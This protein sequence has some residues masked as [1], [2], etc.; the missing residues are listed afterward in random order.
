MLRITGDAHLELGTR[1]AR[2]AAL[3]TGALP[4]SFYVYQGEELGLPEVEDL[5]PEARRDPVWLR[6]GFTDPGRDG[7]R[8]PV[9]WSGDS[10]PFGFSGD[11]PFTRRQR[12]RAVAAAAPVVRGLHRRVRARR[13]RLDARAV[14]RDV[15]RAPCHPA[16]GD[17]ELEWLAADPSVLAFRR[18]VG[19]VCVV[20][21][22]AH[23]Q[24][25]PQHE[26]LLLCSAPLG[27]RPA[28]ARRRGVAGRVAAQRI[29]L[30]V[31]RSNNCR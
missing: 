4:G 6:S 9:P 5:V 15:P 13:R 26:Q 8:V 10:P 25:L 21:F 19:F 14:P 16:L 28:T 27:G 17:G 18:P 7:C 31:S 24:P 1:R 23:P 3:L 11:P 22:G 2:A 12:R 20:N 30:P 29:A